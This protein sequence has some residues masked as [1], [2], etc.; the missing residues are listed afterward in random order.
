MWKSRIA[1]DWQFFYY[2]RRD[3]EREGNELID[4][5]IATVA[6]MLNGDVVE[7]FN[8]HPSTLTKILN[9]DAE[10]ILDGLKN[11]PKG[12]KWIR[13]HAG[14][15]KQICPLPITAS[16]RR[17]SAPLLNE[18]RNNYALRSANLTH[19]TKNPGYVL[20]KQEQINGKILDT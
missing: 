5:I 1:N 8:I 3:K 11:T 15:I 17:V 16:R 19:K 6:L 2:I 12:K 18:I 10:E 20:I 4:E 9:P 13:I 14:Q 7:I